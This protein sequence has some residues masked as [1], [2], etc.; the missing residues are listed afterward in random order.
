VRGVAFMEGHLRPLSGW[1]DFDPGGRELFQQLRTPGVGERMVLRE[2]FFIETLL[3]A[4]M[5]GSL[6]EADLEVY[7]RPFPD[8][9]SRRPLLRWA[10]EIPVAGEPAEVAGIFDAGWRH[11]ATSAVAKLLVHGQPGVVVGPGTLAWCRRT[12]PGLT[13]ADVGPA[14][15]FLP[16]DR[17]AE[18]AAALTAWLDGQDAVSTEAPASTV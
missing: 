2:N 17:P 9:A 12:Q 6:T 5:A 1:D 16:E 7:R 4:A 15:H 13:V 8:P 10:R 18:V 3:P 11:L 14:G